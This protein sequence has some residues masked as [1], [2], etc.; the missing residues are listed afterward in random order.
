MTKMTDVACPVVHHALLAQ[1]EYLQANLPRKQQDQVVVPLI[2][3]ARIT[4][5][6]IEFDLYR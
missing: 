2:G 3:I 1:T 6:P 4:R 5:A